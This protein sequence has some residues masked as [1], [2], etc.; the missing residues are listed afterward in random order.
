MSTPRKTILDTSKSNSAKAVNELLE[1]ECVLARDI[2][3]MEGTNK[4]GKT[5]VYKGCSKTSPGTHTHTQKD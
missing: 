3:P 1:T 4:K 5:Y 2:E